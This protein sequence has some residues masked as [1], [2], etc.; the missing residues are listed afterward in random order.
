MKGLLQRIS[1]KVLSCILAL[2]V[3]LCS[4]T[5]VF[6]VF[7]E[8]T[9]VYQVTYGSPAIPMFTGKTV[10]LN[11]MEVQFEKDGAFVTGDSITWDYADGT[12]TAAV[13]IEKSHYLVANTTGIHKLTA[14]ADGY[15]PKNIYV[16]VN[17]T[18]GD[19][20]FYL[21]KEDL[22]Q[23]AELTGWS[24]Y[25]GTTKLD[26]TYSGNVGSITG[27]D[28]NGTNRVYRTHDGYFEF[29]N[30]PAGSYRYMVYNSDIIKDFAD[31]TVSSSMATTGV[32]DRT[33]FITR[34]DFSNNT[35]L[36]LYYRQGAGVN[37]AQMNSI[38]MLGD[39]NR[40][41]H[42]LGIGGYTDFAN[43][44]EAY[45]AV[46]KYYY[47]A[48]QK[49]DLS[50]TVSGSDILVKFED[51]TVFDSKEAVIRLGSSE[52]DR[53][54]NFK[55][56]FAESG[57]TDA[58]LVGFVQ[59]NAYA[60]RTHLY[61][62][63]VKLNV[64]G[65]DDMPTFVDPD[66]DTP[67]VAVPYNVTYGSPAIPMFVDKAVDL[68]Y[69]NVQFT[70]DGDYVS[71]NSI[72]WDYADS[73]D[74]TAVTFKN[75]HYLVA[76][77]TGIHTLT[78]TANG[79]TKNIYVVVNNKD[80]YDFYLAKEDLTQNAEL[81]G[82]SFYEGT[83][84]LDITYSGNV[85]SITGSD[86][87]GTNRVYRTHDGYFEF[88]NNPAGS[89][90]Y[91]VY[92][93]DIIKDFADYT[94]SSS[95]AT[96]GVVDRTGFI[97]RGDFSNNTAL[98]LY[99]RQGAG[100]NVAQMNSICMLGDANRGFHTL[101]IGGYTDFANGTEAYTE[102][103]KYYYGA[104]QKYDLSATVS[105]SDILVK[106]EGQTVF[107][108][109][110]AVIRL[111][112][113]ETD[114]T[115]DFK[116]AFAESGKTDAGLVGF[117]QY[118][119][120]SERTHL[121]SFSVKLNV[122]SAEDL[123]TFVDPDADSSEPE[124]EPDVYIVR[125]GNP[126]IPMTAG[127]RI[128]LEKFAVQIDDSFPIADTLIWDVNNATGISVE[129]GYLNAYDRGVYSVKVSNGSDTA[130]IHI[131]VKSPEESEYVVFEKDYRS[132]TT[133]VSEW[134]TT[135]I[136]EDE[137][138]YTG[139]TYSGNYINNNNFQYD[140]SSVNDHPKGFVPY[141]AEELE[142]ALSGSEVAVYTTLNNAVVAALSD[143][144][145]TAN[146]KA[147]PNY[148]GAVGVIGR[149]V[150][151][152]EGK[153]TIGSGAGF[154]LATGAQDD[155]ITSSTIPRNGG[156]AIHGSTRTT[157]SNAAV[158]EYLHDTV[159]ARQYMHRTFEISYNGDTATLTTPNGGTEIL[160]GISTQIGTV[161]LVSYFKDDNANV[162]YA[163]VPVL[164]DIKI[165]LNNVDLSNLQS[166]DIP[167]HTPSGLPSKTSPYVDNG[168]YT[169]T[170]DDT[171]MITAYNIVDSSIGYSEKVTIP[172]EYDSMGSV[173]RNSPKN[174]TLGEVVIGEG[175]KYI[176]DQAFLN[177]Y[178]LDTV[179]FPTSLI[180]VGPNAFQNSGVTDISFPSG[181]KLTAIDNLAFANCYSLRSLE[182]PEGLET[183]GDN[184]FQNAVSLTSVKIPASVTA[185]G[186]S[187]FAG[188][189]ILNEVY[190]Y[191]STVEIGSGAIPA[192]TTI[193]GFE[194]STAQEYAESNGN[195][196]VP[197]N[198]EHSVSLNSKSYLPSTLYGKS[199]VWPESLEN[200]HFEIY[201]TGVIVAL[202]E[203]SVSVD[204][205]VTYNGVDN[206]M[207]VTITVG[208]YDSTAYNHIVQ[209]DK[210]LITN[211]G[212]G[213][214]SITFDDGLLVKYDT[215]T[216]NGSANITVN[217]QET[218]TVPT[219]KT[220]VFNVADYGAENLQ[221]IKVKFE[222][223]DTN[224]NSGCVY[225]L[226]ATT[227][228]FDNGTYGLRVTSR[229]PA[230]KYS[231][232]DINGNYG[233]FANEVVID[234]ETA[235][236][237]AAGS[238]VCP[239][240]L[241]GN[242]ELVLTNSEVSSIASGE[243]VTDVQIGDYYASNVIIDKLSDLTA[244]YADYNV[245]LTA[246]PENMC[247][248]DICFRNYII[249]EADGKIAIKYEDIVTKDYDTVTKKANTPITPLNVAA[250]AVK[251]ESF[252]NENVVI[253]WGDS[254][255]ESTVGN[256]YPSQLMQNLGGQYLVY[257]A[258]DAGETAA[259]ILSRAN[260]E[261]IYL[262][263][264]ITFAAGSEYSDIFYRGKLPEGANSAN[265][266]AYTDCWVVDENGKNVYYTRNGN[267]L[268]IATGRNESSR[269]ANVVINGVNYEL[270]EVYENGLSTY[271]P[272]G[273]TS[274]FKLKRT[275]NT[276]AA[277]TLTA[278]TQVTY[279]HSASYKKA[280]V[281][282]VLYG[283]NGY[284]FDAY[285]NDDAQK[286][287]L[288]AQFKQMSGTADKMLY[289]IPYFWSNDITNEFVEAFGEDA[290][291]LVHIR[292]YLRDGAFEDYDVTP[293]EKDLYYINEMN[294]TPYCFMA[295]QP[296]DNS[297]DCHMSQLGY[298]I[299]ADLIYKQGVELGYWK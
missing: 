295:T 36:L 62:F 40:G 13:S 249:Y 43:G 54:T 235:T 231:G 125:N 169:F 168:N 207:P 244:I 237:I 224:T 114:R 89:Y 147:Y 210:A 72:T 187:A 124:P 172:G 6:S 1:K 165:V 156:I 293:T 290:N 202:K 49:Y 137:T 31:Y 47:G 85:G 227:K 216:I 232:T 262:Q 146:I 107:D 86:A 292:E 145:V 190:I 222:A 82:W 276:T 242:N 205:T 80:D 133:D 5:C 84:K 60:E 98:L 111:G 151:T 104:N 159:Y 66:A 254:I 53:T 263:Y 160:S 55:N 153:Y 48:N 198:M 59:Y 218:D 109:K 180:K 275:G 27:S 150:T 103:G 58:G 14:T 298:K 90:R 134:V 101:G 230:I 122:T 106:F 245:L 228:A 270:I 214:Y 194:G 179:S 30:N 11:N 215:F 123:P 174:T 211:I 10:D 251:P 140:W 243:T 4:V 281:G 67:V 193:Y 78:A 23:N 167:S 171:N 246:I 200:E 191:N 269:G 184:A 19:Y 7:A 91:M 185:I 117:V 128:S 22:T 25:E 46:G 186:A 201:D 285:H 81:T 267:Q 238:L 116:N 28:A 33:G 225:T 252:E 219:G 274:T 175:F 273:K 97:T 118:N 256:S 76:N 126:V 35:A 157:V 289:I 266:S 63:S 253:S 99:Y 100:V 12:D 17:E 69:I 130:T 143:Y 241:L 259:A 136:T 206:I 189:T 120:Y 52:S 164:S 279:D 192:G 110:E 248:I 199:I 83:T 93:S 77:K 74:T 282:I 37:V 217:E 21:A 229:I 95:M 257:N 181:S 68:D 173:F 64:T 294:M 45:T 265:S 115:T 161:G 280:D 296:E 56:A 127:T 71:G 261:E 213:N 41:F 65:T 223:T 149:A 195:V 208:D 176:W 264:D 226:G 112:S 234:G 51:Q 87:N 139:K 105:G 209:T 221:N 255:T 278:G 129:D 233:Q 299:L 158:S 212:D 152:N 3:L 291:K 9:D 92:N 79:S 121:Y 283:A 288:I 20:D 277:L 15:D 94:V 8:S 197:L 32:V 220:F 119:A 162:P 203:G 39:A 26:I 204:C 108:S 2:A 57:K 75:E 16:V 42:T 144:K 135:V 70:K 142:N 141:N 44:K 188:C 286:Q 166:E 271:N 287:A 73:T 284:Y 297:Y 155:Y 131:V 163:S 24:F 132:E 183:I 29:M 240:V 260:L 34:G 236:P 177:N 88:M 258:G 182:L 61:S 178:F 247:D 250:E 102:V 138:E 170:V 38:C 50:A 96:T 154:A 18:E 113:S 239:E 196:F 148:R 272:W 268:P